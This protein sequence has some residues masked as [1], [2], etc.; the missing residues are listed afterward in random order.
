METPTATRIWHDLHYRHT[1]PATHPK[2]WRPFIEIDPFNSQNR[3][4]GHIQFIGG[5][6][7]GA[8]AISHVNDRPAHPV[9]QGYAQGS[10]PFPQGRFLG[11]A[12]RA[13]GIRL[14]KR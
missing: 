13:G 5:D 12:R 7:Y 11:A 3:V 8:L 2:M 10:L 14:S 4:A 9:H 1:E 6:E